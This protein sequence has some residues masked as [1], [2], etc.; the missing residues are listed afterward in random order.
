MFSSRLDLDLSTELLE[1]EFCAVISRNGTKWD[2]RK[3]IDEGRKGVDGA[4]GS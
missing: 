3:G 2:V 4:D 1:L